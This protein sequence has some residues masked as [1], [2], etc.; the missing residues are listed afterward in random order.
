MKIY[1]GNLSYETTEDDLAAEFGTFGKVESVAIP[2]DKFSGRPRG[3]AF[4]E[5]ASKSE[6][7][8]A[9]AGSIY[10]GSNSVEMYAQMIDPETGELI[11][12]K[13]VYQED[14]DLKTIREMSE[15]LALKFKLAMPVI[16]GDVVDVK[17]QNIYTDLGTDNQI[18]RGMRL[19][20]FRE[21]KLITHPKTRKPLGLETEEIAEAVVKSVYEKM[22][23][24]ELIEHRRKA[25]VVPLDRVI[26]K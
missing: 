6:A 11:L 23:I 25:E 22:S 18:L 12:A 21:G 10:E 4:V 17:G 24:G 7:E 26:T 20:V 2:S 8:A 14:K 16:E 5:M 1:V 19:V 15:A 3:F 13:D 9:I